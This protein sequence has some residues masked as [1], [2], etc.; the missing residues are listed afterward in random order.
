M[1]PA[2][3][4]FTILFL[5]GTFLLAPVRSVTA[6]RAAC[7]DSY[8]ALA[9]STICEA[10]HGMEEVPTAIGARGVGVDIRPIF[11]ILLL[12]STLLASTVILKRKSL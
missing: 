6:Q 9:D 7:G 5:I 3:T 1:R 12:L 4:V 8:S 10:D 2:L 11:P